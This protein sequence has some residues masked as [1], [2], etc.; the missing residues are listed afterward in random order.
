MVYICTLIDLLMS[1]Q[2]SLCPSFLVAS[3]LV[4]QGHPQHHLRMPRCLHRVPGRLVPPAT[5]ALSA[6]LH[7]HLALQVWKMA[8]LL[9]HPSAFWEKALESA[10]PVITVVLL[11][12]EARFSA[13]CWVGSS[14]GSS[15]VLSVGWYAWNC[16][17]EKC[18]YSTWCH[19]LSLCIGIEISWWPFPL[20]LHQEYSIV[21]GPQ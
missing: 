11:Q 7:P 15:S 12:T 19:I 20:Q 1:H 13:L 14:A 5:V 2:T 21:L 10:F 3:L 6:A 8:F 4:L 9:S 18:I 17:K 16:A